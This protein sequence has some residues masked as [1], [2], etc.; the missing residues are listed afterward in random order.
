MVFLLFLLFYI[1][2]IWMIPIAFLLFM[3]IKTGL[4]IKI[5]DNLYIDFCLVAKHAT[6][7]TKRWVVCSKRI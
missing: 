3:I 5:A 7:Q 1:F 6:S 4:D 2:T